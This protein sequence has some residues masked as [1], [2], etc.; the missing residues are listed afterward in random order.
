[1]P[2]IAFSGYVT[3]PGTQTLSSTLTWAQSAGDLIVLLINY[4]G[5]ITQPSDTSGNVYTQFGTPSS[6]NNSHETIYYCLGA[7]AAGAGANTV[8]IAQSAPGTGIDFSVAVFGFSAP[9]HTWVQDQ[10][11][12]NSQG[13]ATAITTGSVTTTHAVEVL[14]SGTAADNSITARSGGSWVT[15]PLDSQGDAQEYL[16][17]DS[18]QTDIAATY[19]Q[20]MP[21]LGMSQLGTFAV[22]P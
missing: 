4:D 9:G 3:T 8:T 12:N 20:S 5:S 15:E 19:T 2:V 17:V 16:I 14:V 7:K 13:N 22:E 6:S 11:I 10:Y 1:M 18:V 21:G